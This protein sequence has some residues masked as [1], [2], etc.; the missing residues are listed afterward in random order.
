MVRINIDVD[1]ESVLLHEMGHS[2]GLA[3]CNAAT[4]S[5]ETGDLCF[6]EFKKKS[7]SVLS[8]MV[9]LFDFLFF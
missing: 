9:F 2:L 1:F 4:E 7:S 5:G 8:M 6:E 3:H